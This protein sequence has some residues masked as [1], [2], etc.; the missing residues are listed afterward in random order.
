MDTSGT[1]HVQADAQDP[2]E[3]DTNCVRCGYNLRGLDLNGQCPECGTAVMR[4]V[5]GGY[6]RDCDPAWV[7]RVASGIGLIL[8]SVACLFAAVIAGGLSEASPTGGEAIYG[9]VLLASTFAFAV[10]ALWGSF[11]F[12]A[13]DPGKREHHAGLD[14]RVL[15]RT[16]A[17][18][19]AALMLMAGLSELISP[20]MDPVF[21]VLIA[22]TGV[23]GWIASL[24]YAE[25]LARRLPN[26]RLARSTRT[27]NRWVKISVLLPISPI[28]AIWC[29]F[30]MREY[31]RQ[32]RQTA[33][34]ARQGTMASEGAM[35]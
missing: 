26:E 21:G 34:L 18:V 22:I 4:S 3:E 33:Q 24:T 6:L 7:E 13:R 27:T 15:F 35:E 1:P 5:Q 14:A 23:V 9:I 30:L 25:E 11:R 28:V 17:I 8:W 2:I 31:R 12:S 20:S 29:L 16:T 19:Q 10:L 32:L